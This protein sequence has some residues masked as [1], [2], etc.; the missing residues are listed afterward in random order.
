MVFIF[1][2]LCLVFLG[3]IHG[4]TPTAK[5]TCPPSTLSAADITQLSVYMLPATVQLWCNNKIPLTS[6]L[7]LNDRTI[8]HINNNY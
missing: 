1:G 2:L 5:I 6:A 3:T 7:M 4:L 8:L